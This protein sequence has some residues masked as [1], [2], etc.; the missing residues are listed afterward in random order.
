[1]RKRLKMLEKIWKIEISYMEEVYLI[2][3]CVDFKVASFFDN[4]HSMNMIGIG[5]LYEPFF[6]PYSLN[7]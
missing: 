2:V 7:V 1:M 4:L 6:H 3:T 5:E